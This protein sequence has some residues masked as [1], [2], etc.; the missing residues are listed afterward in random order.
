MLLNCLI[1]LHW[2]YGSMGGAAWCNGGHSLTLPLQNLN[3][4]SMWYF[5]GDL[6]ITPL[7]G[8]LQLRPSFDYMNKGEAN[9]IQASTN[10]DEGKLW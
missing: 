8:V 4:G 10:Q 1:S 3:Q 2:M 9:T 5:V 7:Q 6:H